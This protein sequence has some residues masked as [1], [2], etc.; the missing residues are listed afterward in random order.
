MNSV[1]TKTFG[2]LSKSYYFRQFIFG[3]IFPAIMLSTEAQRGAWPPAGVIVFIVLNTFLYPY[4]RFV[5]ERVVGFIVGDNQFYINAFL[6]LFFKVITMALCWVFAVFVAP[7]GLIYLYIHHSRAA[8][9][10]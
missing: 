3:A 8:S 2:G 7:V 10:A 5:Y 4:S 1:I 9:D 6:M